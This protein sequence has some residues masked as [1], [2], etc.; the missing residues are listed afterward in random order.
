[1]N[2]RGNSNDFDNFYGMSSYDG[3]YWGSKTEYSYN[4]RTGSQMKHI[5]PKNDSTWNILHLRGQHSF[6]VRVDFT[7]KQKKILIVGVDKSKKETKYIKAGWDKLDYTFDLPNKFKI[8][9]PCLSLWR[10]VT[11]KVEDMFEEEWNKIM[12]KVI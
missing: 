12:K 3:L 5:K 11:A 10:P 2:G 9:Y 8:W 7:K 6:F 4:R 1:M